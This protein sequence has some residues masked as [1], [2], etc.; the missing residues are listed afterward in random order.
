[1]KK[2]QL[3][4]FKTFLKDYP[5]CRVKLVIDT[6]S[7]V[8]LVKY[9]TIEDKFFINENDQIT[10]YGLCPRGINTLGSTKLNMLNT[11]TKFFIISDDIYFPADMLLGV[12][13]LHKS[14]A[15]VSFTRGAMK[16]NFNVTKTNNKFTNSL[17][18]ENFQLTSQIKG[19][20]MHKSAID[21]LEIEGDAITFCYSITQ[22]DQ[23]QLADKLSIDIDN[24]GYQKGGKIHVKKDKDNQ[25]LPENQDDGDII[26][27]FITPEELQN[28]ILKDPEGALAIYGKEVLATFESQVRVL[29]EKISQENIVV[30]D[31]GYASFQKE[32]NLQRNKESADEEN[33]KFHQPLISSVPALEVSAALSSKKRLRLTTG[34]LLDQEDN[35]A[36]FTTSDCFFNTPNAQT[37]IRLKHFDPEEIIKEN[38]TT[39][40]ALCLNSKA[41]H[42]KIIIIFLE[43]YFA[44]NLVA[45]D[46]RMGLKVLRETMNKNS[47]TNVRLSTRGDLFDNISHSVY[48]RIAQSIF[49]NDSSLITICIQTKYPQPYDATSNTQ[50]TSRTN[51]Q[52]TGE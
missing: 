21:Q 48:K 11:F 29:N 3:P 26:D 30:E 47:V 32:T 6:A 8:N 44:K 50:V 40:G 42:S 12:E 38:F 17:H 25:I 10:I 20:E 7:S 51:F 36:I 35:Y 45:S 34:Q 43:E 9:S 41:N 52:P 5:E 49:N 2:Q 4:Y 18:D 14:K 16:L 37:L 28:E 22:A 31:Q 1:M 24:S 33:Y 19:M 23:F 13:F 27:L 15:Q 46:L 39:P